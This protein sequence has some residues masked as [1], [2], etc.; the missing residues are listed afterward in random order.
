MGYETIKVT[1][2]GAVGVI[3]FD[4]PSQLQRAEFRGHERG[5]QS[6]WRLRCRPGGRGAIVLTGS[7]KAFAAGADKKE[8]ADLSYIDAMSSNFFGD[9]EDF[10][11]TSKPTIA[12]V[13]GYALGGGCE[14]AMMCDILIAADSAKFGQPEITLGVMPGMG[15]SQR[16]TRA[17]GKAKAMDLILTAG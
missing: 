9:W 14:V 13:A 4:R 10:T 1:T 16:L 8:M 11:A 3:T 6:R 7:A 5:G 2:E 17:V 15:G 12:A